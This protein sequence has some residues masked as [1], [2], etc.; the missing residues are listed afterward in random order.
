MIVT[1]NKEFP[2][3]E[4]LVHFAGRSRIR[5]LEETKKY[6]NRHAQPILRFVRHI[7]SSETMLLMNSLGTSKLEDCGA[8]GRTIEAYFFLKATALIVITTDLLG[9]SDSIHLQN[10]GMRL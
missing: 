9:I 6:T 4:L 8:K 10:W 5:Y 2:A 3:Y 1:C 7:S